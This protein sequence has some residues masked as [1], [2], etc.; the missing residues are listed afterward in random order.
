M[1]YACVISGIPGHEIEDVHLHNMR[2]IYPGGGKGSWTRREPWEQFKAIPILRGL[3]EMPSYGFFI[4]HVTGLELTNV[5]MVSLK[6]DV[7]PPF[8]VKDVQ[9][10]YLEHVTAMHGEQD[11]DV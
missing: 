6:P 4:R 11:A 9:D 7:R 10:F 1:S 8:F 2:L 3:A 5:D